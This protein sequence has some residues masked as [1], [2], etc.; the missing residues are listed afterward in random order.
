MKSEKETYPDSSSI[1]PNDA[2]L[3]RIVPL[4]QKIES[5]QIN[6]NDLDKNLDVINEIRLVDKSIGLQFLVDSG[7]DALA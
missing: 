5:M 7:A 6:E 3:A 2:L 1:N 4:E